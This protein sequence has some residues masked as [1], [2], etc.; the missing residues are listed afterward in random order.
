MFVKEHHHI[1]LKTEPETVIQSLYYDAHIAL[2]LSYLQQNAVFTLL[3]P[4]VF[5]LIPQL[6]SFST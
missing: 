1:G 5:V 2:R 6:F 3:C 4:G